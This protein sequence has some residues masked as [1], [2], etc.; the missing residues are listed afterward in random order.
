M[1]RPNL[2]A[3]V[4]SS[5]AS[6]SS[7]RAADGDAR[8]PGSCGRKSRRPGSHRR[9]SSSS[10][11]TRNMGVRLGCSCCC[12][13]TARGLREASRRVEAKVGRGVRSGRRGRRAGRRRG[14]EARKRICASSTSLQPVKPSRARWRRPASSSRGLP[15]CRSP[16]RRLLACVAIRFTS[17]DFNDTPAHPLTPRRLSSLILRLPAAS[18]RSTRPN[19]V[20]SLDTTTGGTEVALTGLL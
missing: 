7:A 19:S 1:R 10:G 8:Q 6:V 15:R 11:R 16:R 2:S 14:V 17:D 12:P 5:Q 18:A 13:S 4:V 20:G 9:S 3:R